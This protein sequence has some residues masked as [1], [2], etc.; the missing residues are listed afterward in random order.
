M[1]HQKARDYIQLLQGK[2]LFAVYRMADMGCFDFGIG[3]EQPY[4]AYAVHL[5]CPFRLV[6]KDG[7]ILFAAYDMYL[8]HDGEWMEDMSWD[9]SGANLFD[10]SAKEWFNANPDL[11]VTSNLLTVFGDLKIM[12]SNEDYLEVFVNQS[13]NASADHEC[14]RFFERHSERAHLV[15]S[16]KGDKFE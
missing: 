7:K 5:Q 3:E 13:G 8:S 12:F 2:P 15:V 10:K 1:I 14:W 11:Y 16:G 6:S 4:S 9:V